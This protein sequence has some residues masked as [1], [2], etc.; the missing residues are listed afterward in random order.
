MWNGGENT[1]LFEDFLILVVRAPLVG[2]FAHQPIT[3]TRLTQLT[4]EAFGADGH[5]D[6]C[7]TGEGD[8]VHPEGF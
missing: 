2:Y 7:K 4:A 1:P 6:H 3:V 5:E 8:D